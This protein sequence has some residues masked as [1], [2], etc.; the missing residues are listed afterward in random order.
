MIASENGAGYDVKIVRR[1]ASPDATTADPS[2][3]GAKTQEGAS[4]AGDEADSNKKV[5]R[6]APDNEPNKP[7]LH[8]S[9][10]FCVFLFIYL[11]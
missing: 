1:E 10:I 4:A 5:R 3:S 6:Q 8:V 2:G 9:I 11:C 7:S